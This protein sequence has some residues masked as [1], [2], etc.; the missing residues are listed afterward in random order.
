MK[1]WILAAASA[2]FA[3]SVSAAPFDVPA[4]HAGKM[5]HVLKE[6]DLNDEQKGEVRDILSAARE[7]VDIFADDRKQQRETIKQLVEADA[8]DQAAVEQAFLANVDVKQQRR[9]NFAQVRH[10]IWNVLDTEQQADLQEMTAETKAE[11]D[12]NKRQKVWERLAKR[13]G[14]TEAQQQ[15]IDAIRSAFEFD[16]STVR[17]TMKA[18]KDAEK[19]LIQTADFDQAAWDSLFQEHQAFTIELAV[20]KAYMQHQI[21]QVLTP[22]QREQ[23]S[24]AERKIRK[25]M[26][27]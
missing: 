21:L 27:G 15:E 25:K 26:R 8:W 14:V 16:K 17:E 5:I 3:M 2:A 13:I 20:S 23:L 9:L 22:E 1:K 24:K 4:K 10:Q 7:D 12:G 18:H 11:R 6:L 19:A